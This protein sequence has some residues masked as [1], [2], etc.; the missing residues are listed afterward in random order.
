MRFSEII[1]QKAEAELKNRREQAER[2]ADMRRKEFL[3]KNPE[4]ATIENEMK[5]AALEVIR[6]VGANGK[7]VDVSAIAK[8]NLEA[9]QARKE[10]IVAAGYPEDYLDIPYSCKLCKDSGILN[11][12]LCECHLALLQQLS[13]GELA[14]SPMLAGSTFSTFDVNYYSDIK[15]PRTGYSP[16]DYMGGFLAMLKDYAENF[17][18]RSNSFFFSGG[19]GLGKTHLALAVLNRLTQRGYSVYYSSA[20]SLLKQMEKE[21]FGRSADTIEEDLF[22]NDLI[23]IDDLGA[24]F[25]TAFSQAAVNELINN[26]ILSGKAMIIISNLSVDELEERYGQRVVSRLNSFEVITFEGEDIRQLKKY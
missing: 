26:A 16:R 23:I 11:G 5:N 7:S 1:Y 22:N 21:R 6:S 15:D 13:V 3:G 14:C 9:Q 8:R 18:P 10:L 2:L 19:T 4:L 24:E 17:T 25:S 12:K 20:G